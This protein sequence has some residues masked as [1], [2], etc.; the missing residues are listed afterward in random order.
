MAAVFA[1]PETRGSDM[2]AC[3]ISHAHGLVPELPH[4]NIHTLPML[5]YSAINLSL[6]KIVNDM[7]F[8]AVACLDWTAKTAIDYC[9]RPGNDDSHKLTITHDLHKTLLLLTWSQDISCSS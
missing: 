2:E 8:A 3:L 9:D 1:G 6:T 5:H 4:S 7:F